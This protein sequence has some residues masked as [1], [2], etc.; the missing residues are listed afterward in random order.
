[1]SMQK[2]WVLLHMH[3]LGDICVET[4]H[5][6]APNRMLVVRKMTNVVVTRSD[7]GGPLKNEVMKM[8]GYALGLLNDPVSVP[9]SAIAFASVAC[10]G[11]AHACESAWT[12]RP[13]ITIHQPGDLKR[14]DGDS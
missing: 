3:G 5:D 8:P 4:E 12:G 10:K 13:N 9:P 14:L 6:L 2:R 7:Q 11:L 1:M